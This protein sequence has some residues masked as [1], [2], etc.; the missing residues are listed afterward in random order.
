MSLE[1]SVDQDFPR[2]YI[3]CCSDD[4]TV[5]P[6]HT[7][8]LNDAMEKAGIMHKMHIFGSGGH[9]IALGEGTEAQGWLKEA[10]QFFDMG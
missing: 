9:A 7:I 8:L 4:A 2:T 1:N 5:D 6:M 10:L 3:W